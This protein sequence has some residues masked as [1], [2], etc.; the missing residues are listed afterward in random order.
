MPTFAQL[1]KQYA[2]ERGGSQQATEQ[3]LGMGTASLTHYI[4]G[5]RAPDLKTANRLIAF[6]K[7]SDAEAEEF[8][9]LAKKAKAARH[10]QSNPYAKT[11]EAALAKANKELAKNAAL[12]S[13]Q[14]T[15]L[16]AVADQ[17][18]GSPDGP[19]AALGRQIKSRLN[20]HGQGS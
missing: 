13:E 16:H 14:A 5:R 4:A 15:L 6:W 7:L 2:S 18:S 20:M 9:L 19:L 11:M 3:G 12:L 10:V 17:L 1:V 8:R